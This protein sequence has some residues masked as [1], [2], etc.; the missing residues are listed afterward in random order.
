MTQNC[1]LFVINATLFT[2]SWMLD[3]GMDVASKTV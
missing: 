3:C 2:V 1:I